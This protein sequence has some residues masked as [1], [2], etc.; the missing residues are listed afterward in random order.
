MRM[1]GAAI[2]KTRPM[3]LLVEIRGDP[4][5]RRWGGAIGTIGATDY[6][7]LEGEQK[8][9]FYDRLRKVASERLAAGDRSAM[10]IC[11]CPEDDGG[12]GPRLDDLVGDKPDDQTIEVSSRPFENEKDRGKPARSS[13]DD[14][15]ISDTSA[16]NKGGGARGYKAA[17]VYVEATTT[18]IEANFARWSSSA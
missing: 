15:T 7:R 4:E 8:E 9:D 11:V 6:P 10:I 12:G 1:I 17:G 13:D 16:D 2:G 3:P 18:G 14:P 5:R